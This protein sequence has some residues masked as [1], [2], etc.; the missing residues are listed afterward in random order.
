[1]I[2]VN[3]LPAYAMDNEYIVVHKSDGEYWFY[4]AFHKLDK[5]NEV[6][7]MVHGEVLATSEVL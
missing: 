3:N 6:A 7:N 5:A 4:G 2:K 1:M